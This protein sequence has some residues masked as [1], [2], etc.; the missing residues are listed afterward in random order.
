EFQWLRGNPAKADADAFPSERL[1]RAGRNEEY[2]TIFQIADWILRIV[3]QKNNPERVEKP[4]CMIR[5]PVL[6]MLL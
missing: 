3:N 2:I 6:N 5:I 4:E 1:I